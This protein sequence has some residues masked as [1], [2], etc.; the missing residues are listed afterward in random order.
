MNKKN[1]KKIIALLSCIFLCLFLLGA[2]SE[3]KSNNLSDTN[4]DEIH[5][6]LDIMRFDQLPTH[7]RTTADLSVFNNTNINTKGM[8]TLNISG[9]EQFSKTNLPML[10][11]AIK[12]PYK[13]TDIDLRQESHG[14]INELPISW[15]NAL[16]NANAG[17]NLS[18]INMRENK[19]LKSVPLNKPLT[20][21]NRPDVT[22]TPTVTYTE[23]TLVKSNGLS[24]IRIPVTDFDLPD[25]SAVDYFLNLVKNQPKNSWLHFHCKEGVGRTTTFMIM[26]DIIKNCNYVSLDDIITR[27]VNF[28]VSFKEET[29]AKF[30]QGKEFVFLSKFYEYC[31]SNAKDNNPSWSNWIKLHI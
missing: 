22:I 28:P 6:I 17:L 14:F 3:D 25:N 9:S 26:Y 29:K 16:D 27:Q 20:F 8:S 10:V 1:R 11:D 19:L 18:Q 24:Y 2:A 5:L 23:E 30:S 4:S 12:S 31:K 7:F 21:Y 15:A 13:I